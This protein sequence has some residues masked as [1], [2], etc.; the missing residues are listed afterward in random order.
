M[1]A[2]L[3]RTGSIAVVLIACSL[4]VRAGVPS[5]N[6]GDIV[7]LG[8]QS[9]APDSFSWAPLVDLRPGT[10]IFF[11]DIGFGIDFESTSDGALRYVAPRLIRAGEIQVVTIEDGAAPTGYTR[12]IGDGMRAGNFGDQIAVFAGTLARPQF[13][14][15]I[16]TA[17]SDWGADRNPPNPSTDSDLYPGL[18]D[19]VNAVALGAGPQSGQEVDNAV[20]RGPC[21]GSRE[22]LLAAI[23]NFE[24]WDRSDDPLG[25]APP[26]DELEVV[27]GPDDPT[28]ERGDANTDGITD[29]ADAVFV[30]GYLFQGNR[31]PT[32]LDAADA[33]DDGGVDISDASALLG[34]LFLGSGPPP[35]PLT[36]CGIDPTDDAIG[37]ESFGPCA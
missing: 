29:I 34:Y 2:S 30:L 11:T 35:P 6:P 23:A 17:S 7:I 21:R 14:F 3:R 32:C 13:L 22:E 27:E 16:H 24:I 25:A 10:R 31:T 28:F 9:D 18:T 19:G 20:Y 5:L 1:A 8:I 26:C 12:V 4:S 15:A 33:N 36:E 37:C